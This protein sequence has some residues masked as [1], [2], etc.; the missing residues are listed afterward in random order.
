MEKRRFLENLWAAQARYRTKY[1]QSVILCAEE[2]EVESRGDRVTTAKTYFNLY[3]RTAYLKEQAK[4]WM[5][6]LQSMVCKDYLPVM[7]VM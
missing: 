1:G 2:S 3:H 4:V 6:T 7:P 5:F